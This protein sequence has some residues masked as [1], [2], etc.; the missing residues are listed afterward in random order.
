MFPHFYYLFL[1]LIGLSVFYP[2]YGSDKQKRLEYSSKLKTYKFSSITLVYKISSIF[3]TQNKYIFITFNYFFQYFYT[4]NS[5]I[6]FLFTIKNVFNYTHSQ[7]IY[8]HVFIFILVRIR[9][10][11]KIKNISKEMIFQ[12][13]LSYLNDDMCSTII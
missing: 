11:Q 7:F 5:F 10:Q 12:K 2:L 4:W 3:S 6:L 8:I 13:K 1:I 9:D